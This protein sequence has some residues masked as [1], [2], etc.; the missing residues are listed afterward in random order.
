MNNLYDAKKLTHYASSLLNCAGL[1]SEIAQVVAETLV[2]GD[3]LG[4]DTHGLGLLASYIKEIESAGMKKAGSPIVISDKPGVILWDGQRLP[5]PWLL[6]QAYKT[7]APRARSL[8]VASLAIKRSHHIA[9]LAVY[10]MRALQDGYLM[11]LASSDANSASVAPFGGTQAVFT[12]NPIA[13]GFPVED[14]GVMIDISASITTNGMTNRKHKAGEKF[15]HN[16]LMTSNG[17]PTNDPSVMFTQPPGTLLGVGGQDHGHKGYGLSLM[18]EA[19]TAGLA[20]RGRVDPKEGWGATV[21][22]TLYDIRSFCGEAEFKRQM[23]HV[24]Q[25]CKSN[26]PLNPQKPVRLPGQAGF[27]K[28]ETQLKSGVSLHSSIEPSLKDAQEKYGFKLSDCL[29]N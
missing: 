11:I 24:A 19:L 20:G 5:G 22:I 29:I 10:L 4:H 8:G 3:L 26:I 18:V 25:L 13:I 6:D 28:R 27:T 23:D 21:H 15:E 7:L 2:E 12:P 1:D 14:C 17:E 16:W 9:C